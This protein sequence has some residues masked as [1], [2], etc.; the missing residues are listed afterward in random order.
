ME[1]ALTAVRCLRNS[2]YLLPLI[3]YYEQNRVAGSS[4]TWRRIS[5]SAGENR[6]SSLETT[7]SSPDEFKAWFFE[8]EADEG[9][10]VRDR[11]DANY[12][13]EELAAIRGLLAQLDG[14]TAVRVAQAG[15][16]K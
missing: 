8:K 4:S 11:G 6:A 15:R 7:I 10:E 16:Q 9:Q 12:E 14:F 13:D 2:G 5:I 1:A 3:V